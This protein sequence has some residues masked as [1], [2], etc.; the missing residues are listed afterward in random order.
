MRAIVQLE[1]GSWSKVVDATKAPIMRFQLS[2]NPPETPPTAS[3]FTN[4]ATSDALVPVVSQEAHSLPDEDSSMAAAI[5]DDSSETSDQEAA[6]TTSL[7]TV[8]GLHSTT[9]HWQHPAQQ[10]LRDATD[11][12]LF[13]S[14]VNEGFV[15]FRD[16]T[17]LQHRC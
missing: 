9:L 12:Q 8:F 5:H 7:P 11:L 15:V 1:A 16:Q 13:Q 3:S 6:S 17:V 10:C 4:R 14:S 2:E